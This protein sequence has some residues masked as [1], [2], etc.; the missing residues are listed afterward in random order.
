MAVNCYPSGE[1]KRRKRH[2]GGR[3]CYPLSPVRRPPSDQ[4]PRSPRKAA[5]QEEEGRVS[6]PERSLQGLL[7]VKE[8]RALLVGGLRGLEGG[9]GRH[10]RCV[11]L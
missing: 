9:Y 11:A 4:Q 2:D 8:A 3:L 10:A 1:L 6:A 5:V 7:D